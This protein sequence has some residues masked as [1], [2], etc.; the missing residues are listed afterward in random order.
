MYVSDIHLWAYK[1]IHIYFNIYSLS[2][3]VYLYKSHNLLADTARN[4]RVF[5]THWQL[6]FPKIPIKEKR[7]KKQS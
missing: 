2:A 4:G 7:R 6:K 1:L 3:R 5:L